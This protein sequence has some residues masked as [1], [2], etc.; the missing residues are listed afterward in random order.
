MISSQG[1]VYLKSN[2]TITVLFK[3]LSYRKNAHREVAFEPD[4]PNLLK[5][6]IKLLCNIFNGRVYHGVTLII[7]PLNTIV[8]HIFTYSA[9]SVQ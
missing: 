4:H 6:Q 2:E 9:V 8:D 7:Q 1:V 3:F 5:R